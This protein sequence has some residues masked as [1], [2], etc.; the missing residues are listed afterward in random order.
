MYN[1]ERII[2][3]A[4][5]KKEKKRR[6]KKKKSLTKIGLAEEVPLTCDKKLHQRLGNIV[7]IRKM[8]E[9]IYGAL[10]SY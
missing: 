1:S 7:N 10:K 6:V 9:F 5:K 2:C 4:Q 8:G 3:C